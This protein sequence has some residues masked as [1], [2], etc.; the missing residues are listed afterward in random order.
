MSLLDALRGLF[1]PVEPPDV[2]EARRLARLV[3]AEAV[4]YNEEAVEAFLHEQ[5]VSRGLA[6]DLARA[7]QTFIERAGLDVEPAQM[8]FKDEA[9][10]ALGGDPQALQPV[11]AGIMAPATP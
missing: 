8:I 6:E 1:N 5:V 4:L 3:L 2:G 9:H 10:R 11:L 7:Y